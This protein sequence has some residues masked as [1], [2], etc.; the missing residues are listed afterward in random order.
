MPQDKAHARRMRRNSS[1]STF[2]AKL[3]ITRKAVLVLINIFVL[4]F[5]DRTPL[6]SKRHKN[7]GFL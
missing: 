6:P 5:L 7:F 2:K 4:R 1:N 3:M